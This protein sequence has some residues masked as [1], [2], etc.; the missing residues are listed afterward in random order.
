MRHYCTYFDHNYLARGLVLLRSLQRWSTEPF[1]LW[2]LA[3]SEEAE[4]LLKL[5][6]VVGYVGFEG[7]T[8]SE[9]DS[10][11]RAARAARSPQG[12]PYPHGP[13]GHHGPHL[14]KTHSGEVRFVTL[15][16]VESVFP[17]LLVAKGNR[18]TVEYYFT[19]SPVWPLYLFSQEPGLNQVSYVDADM[20]FFGDPR[21]IFE[22]IGEASIAIT[23]HRF[24][25][26]LRAWEKCGRFNVGWLTFRRDEQGLSCLERW[27]SQCLE[28]CYDRAEDGKYGDQAYLDEWPE[29]YPGLCVLDDPGI[30]AA[31][32]NIGPCDVV[33]RKEG[34]TI[35]GSPLLLYHFHG[36]KEISPC[37]YDTMTRHFG[38]PY[39]RRMNEWIYAPYLAEWLQEA[40]RIRTFQK[41]APSGYLRN[42]LTGS[43]RVRTLARLVSRVANRVLGRVLDGRIANG[44]RCGADWVSAN[45]EAVSGQHFITYQTRVVCIPWRA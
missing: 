7:E 45:I 24:P 26:H 15:R 20:C 40:A 16:Q 44:I 12:P 21:Q 8:E 22:R 4:R 36:F 43:S 14:G 33:Q 3:L 37:V 5:F 31:I 42:A 17:E 23:P 19:L 32:W 1:C 2:V 11:T 18:S 30:N 13:Q 29:R 25:E 10:G 28:W 38:V 39:S 41:K 35:D 34:L 27:K 6:G 9:V